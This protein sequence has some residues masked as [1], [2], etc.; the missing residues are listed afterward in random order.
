MAA[1][2]GGEALL[3]VRQRAVLARAHQVAVDAHP[4]LD[5]VAA[6]GEL[7][8]AGTA[9]PAR[10]RLLAGVDLDAMEARSLD[11][12][13]DLLERAGV[14]E[15]LAIAHAVEERYADR[16]LGVAARLELQHRAAEA[17]DAVEEGG[18]R[19][20]AVNDHTRVV[21]A[22]AVAVPLVVRRPGV[23]IALPS[24]SPSIWLGV[25][26][27]FLRLPV[28]QLVLALDPAGQEVT[29]LVVVLEVA[30]LLAVGDLVE[31]RL[32][33]VEVPALDQLLHLAEE[34]GEDAACGCASRRCR[35]RT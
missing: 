7:H 13:R 2:E 30:L 17:L 22:A 24:P 21:A 18:Q 1:G 34:E 9:R 6:A 15:A 10:A 14:G 12:L 5:A 23:R 29:V 28:A 33:D 32:R 31:R 35:R 3:G 20:A 25:D 8:P 16:I 11:D 27:I 19:L 4:A 26:Q